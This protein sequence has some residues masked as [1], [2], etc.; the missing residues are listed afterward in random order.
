MLGSLQMNLLCKKT[1]ILKIESFHL[2]FP[3]QMLNQ[4]TIQEIDTLHQA[5]TH[6]PKQYV[7]ELFVAVVYWSCGGKRKP[8]AELQ[9]NTMMIGAV[10]IGLLQGGYCRRDKGLFEYHKQFL[11]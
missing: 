3:F 4:A 8:E 1:K 9:W 7:K 11:W 2:K 6:S 5:P 10:S